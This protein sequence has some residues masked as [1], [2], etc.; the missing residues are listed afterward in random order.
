VSDTYE[1]TS[2]GIWGDGVKTAI[3]VI[4]IFF[5]LF[6]VPAILAPL[7]AHAFQTPTKELVLEASKHYM[8]H[9]KKGVY[10]NVLGSWVGNNPRYR[11]PIKKE[12]AKNFSDHDMTLIMPEGTDPHELL[13]EWKKARREISQ[14]LRRKLAAEG[15]TPAQVERVISS[16]SIYPPQQLIDGGL[17]SGASKKEVMKFFDTI[18][19]GKR[20]TP[21]LANEELEGLF[22]PGS[23]A[24]RQHYES[25]A[26][27]VLYRDGN[28]V[29]I[30]FTDLQHLREGYGKF[31]L[32]GSAN[33]ADQFS[34]K[35]SEAIEKSEAKDAGKN[36]GRLITFF[37]KTKSLARVEHTSEAE[38]VLRRIQGD[39][40]HVE[41][42]IKQSPSLNAES[43]THLYETWFERNK[44]DLEK[45]I[46]SIKTEIG[47]YKL[48]PN[49]T[50]P[51]EI[52]LIRR[53]LERKSS[54]WTHFLERL[55][56]WK[57]GAGNIPWKGIV[58][59]INVIIFT[60]ETKGLIDIY[61]RDGLKAAMDHLAHLSVVLSLNLPQS[62]LYMMGD[63]SFNLVKQ[64]MS[65][66]V[67]Q[68]QSCEQLLAGIS[69]MPGHAKV[70]EG[71]DIELL[72]REIVYEDELEKTLL[73][74]V[75]M[76][77][78]REFTSSTEKEVKGGLREKLMNRCMPWLIRMWRHERDGM[79]GELLNAKNEIDCLM[80]ANII[81]LSAKI[82]PDGTAK[83]RVGISVSPSQGRRT[84]LDALQRYQD[85]LQD[86][87]G[88]ERL[89][90][91]NLQE[92]V[93]WV[94]DG[95]PLPMVTR[96]FDISG[97][98][99]LLLDPDSRK[100][101][102]LEGAGPHRI[103][104]NYQL[105]VSPLRGLSYAPDLHGYMNRLYGRYK[106]AS[107]IV[108]D[109]STVLL[110]V[111]GPAR[112]GVG[113]TV[114][115][116]VK[117]EGFRK[118]KSGFRFLWYEGETLLQS[119]GPRLTW[120]PSEVKR[121]KLRV[122]L[123]Y[124]GKKTAE[125]TFRVRAYQPVAMEFHLT[126][127]R[128]GKPVNE[129][130]VTLKRAG[131]EDQGI[132]AHGRDG[133]V[134]FRNIQP[135][136]YHYVVTAVGYKRF[137]GQDT[138]TRTGVQTIR[139][140]PGS[141]PE[142][143]AK[144]KTPDIVKG[145][146][147]L[148]TFKLSRQ[149]IVMGL[150]QNVALSATVIT[151]KDPVLIP[152][153]VTS[154]VSW[155]TDNPDILLQ[156][157]GGI[158]VSGNREGTAVVQ[159]TYTTDSGQTR[160]A[161]CRV[162]V[163]NLSGSLPSIDFTL[164]PDKSSYQTGDPITFTEKIHAKNMDDYQFTWYLGGV[165]MQ[166]PSVTY[167]FRE[168]GTYVV[169]LVVKSNLT[170]KEDAF[171]RSIHVEP[172]TTPAPSS[173][174]KPYFIM[175]PKPYS[176]GQ[177]IHFTV[178]N[179]SALQISY[180]VV[181]HGRGTPEKIDNKSPDFSFTPEREGKYG[182]A[183]VYFQSPD[184]RSIRSLTRWI[185]VKSEKGN[186]TGIN[187]GILASRRNRFVMKKIPGAP[188][189]RVCSSYWR[190][191]LH[192]KGS[193]TKPI[194]FQRI[195]GTRKIL[196]RTGL[197]SD[198]YNTGWLVFVPDGRNEIQ[199][200]VYHFDFSR[201]QGV[202]AYGGTLNLHG[203]RVD[204]N[205]LSFV[206]VLTRA[207][208]V[209]WKATDGSVG[210]VRIS[211][212]PRFRNSVEGGIRELFF[213][214]GGGNKD[215][216]AGN[217]A[218]TSWKVI[219]P[220]VEQRFDENWRCELKVSPAVLHVDIVMKTKGLENL[221]YI[222]DRFGN[223]NT[224]LEKKKNYVMRVGPGNHCLP[225]PDSRSAT[226]KKVLGYRYYF[227]VYDAKSKRLVNLPPI[228]GKKGENKVKSALDDA[229]NNDQEE[230][231]LQLLEYKSAIWAARLRNG[232]LQIAGEQNN[233]EAWQKDDWKT[234]ETHV[235]SFTGVGTGQGPLVV[236]NK[237]GRWTAILL[238]RMSGHII[239]KVSTSK[240]IILPGSGRRFGAT[241][242]VGNKCYDFS[243]SNR[244]RTPE[245]D[246][247]THLYTGGMLP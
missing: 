123:L 41:S 72:A 149:Q 126:D 209:E 59:G 12:F 113:E 6:F 35:I 220:G 46:S 105:I 19:N 215:E 185:E 82:F 131:S 246:C 177:K 204:P 206:K 48:L 112:V 181:K 157:R 159:A 43:I 107:R 65:G 87:G 207:T 119:A 120:Q 244:T 104:L 183:V 73:K 125:T 33:L 90:K 110:R 10:L 196:L 36:L 202:Q 142:I 5:L 37:K 114:A 116:H 95:N 168:P 21:N 7:S 62:L 143:K 158:I 160:T 28:T 23:K 192:G 200:R 58:K 30:G 74:Q 60:I 42:V 9:A 221:T 170:G 178:M 210:R 154:K 176:V 138:F 195:S 83:N 201:K 203:K 214:N 94:V 191:D 93:Q 165:E 91:L 226:D 4:R 69:Q 96:E 167:A 128:S 127:D 190:P 8:A 81:T 199:F 234:I 115:F 106:N 230:V 129:A 80:G 213:T 174:D 240:K 98:G 150:N 3:K 67:T 108:L 205:G 71:T 223:I 32:K 47:L 245:V 144:N 25:K 53:M 109:E 101:F 54:N 121:Y 208:I 216:P 225:L 166:G 2:E 148:L 217:H 228:L 237:Q 50:N 102:I 186:S 146:E 212:Y 1:E 173:K 179:A 171:S 78:E 103:E 34:M 161:F 17:P 118:G 197:Q 122:V 152:K 211:K 169:R 64:G 189:T 15:A 76:A 22:G 84:I 124:H 89:G 231:N 70:N 224:K 187:N 52:R 61:N 39:F 132:S 141:S 222:V 233:R 85:R 97:I 27:R 232:S 164:S 14:Y 219:A 227:W 56:K 68:F 182:I 40:A 162:T 134:R 38:K 86:L 20:L 229:Q 184:D 88:R 172:S 117:A 130:R 136:L 51:E 92:R 137:Q 44:L 55:D 145:E 140:T 147:K 188:I 242:R 135:G 193:W 26:G 111:E 180:W 100:D 13:R 49:T 175:T 239:K 31:T 24:Y 243:S 18:D 218:W 241:I 238:D 247:R 151:G 198:G 153:N 156:T 235:N 16:V 194:A 77:V 75:D 236:Y 99:S 139:M 29:R 155:T 133:I 63:L 163:Q 45:A 66:V 79:L 11:D 57:R